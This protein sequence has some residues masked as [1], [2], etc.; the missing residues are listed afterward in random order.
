MP[1]GR[2]KVPFSGKQK[3]Q[4]LIAKKQAK[5]KFLKYEN[6]NRPKAIYFITIV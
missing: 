6:C 5:C 1:Q 2:R 4:Q 3:K